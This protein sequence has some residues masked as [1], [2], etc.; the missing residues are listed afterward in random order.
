MNSK[1]NVK[2]NCQN[3]KKFTDIAAPEFPHP[4]FGL[5]ILGALLGALMVNISFAWFVSPWLHDTLIHP[6]HLTEAS[7]IA[8]E[9]LLNNCFFLPLLLLVVWPFIRSEINF[10]RAEFKNR[11]CRIYYKRLKN[12]LLIQEV[13]DVEPYVKLM[14][15]QLAGALKDTETG[16]LAIIERLNALHGVSANQVDRIQESMINGMSLMEVMRD[17]SHHN[18]QVINILKNYVTEQTDNLVFN[19]NRI[20]VLATQMEELSPLVDSISEIAKQT[21]LLALNAAIEAAR[22]GESGRGFAV[23]ADEV[24][25]LSSLTSQAAENIEL[26]INLAT[27]SAEAELAAANSA[28]VQQKT[29]SELERIIEEISTMENRFNEGSNVLFSV[30]NAVD[31][32]NKDIITRLSETF[33]FLQ[34]QDVFRQRVEHVQQAL[35]ELNQHLQQVSLAM[36]SSIDAFMEQNKCQ[37]THEPSIITPSLQER[38]AGH[39]DNYVM[40]SQRETHATIDGKAP[41]NDAHRPKIELF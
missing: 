16:V 33:G 31:S 41:S 21:N 20:Q 35:G 6:L 34:Y 5:R 40:H 27:K 11:K 37:A 12:T 7:E 36:E 2:S 4:G 30:I 38:M 9:T 26:K 39:K 3:C 10:V 25:K 29:E 32:G 13:Q 8:L 1:F 19:H 18:N 14:Q 15:E 24:R 17:Q 22:A 28:L 23:V